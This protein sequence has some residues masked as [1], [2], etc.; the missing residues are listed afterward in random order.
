[1]KTI[2][3]TLPYPISANRYWRNFRGRTVT[4]AEANRY[5]NAVRHQ[6]YLAAINALLGNVGVEITLHPKKNRDGSAS[7]TV[8]D[9][10]NALKVALDSLQKVAYI[11]D[12]QIKYLVAQYGGALQDGGL[13]V[14][15]YELEEVP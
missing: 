13:T 7:R 12:K 6:A 14:C 3:M 9:L 15:V 5:K 4:S 1:M 11:D 2:T 8:M 10:D